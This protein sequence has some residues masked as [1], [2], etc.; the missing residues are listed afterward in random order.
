MATFSLVDS[1]SMK[2]VFPWGND[3]S[4]DVGS[5]HWIFAEKSSD[6]EQIQCLA[7][8]VCHSLLHTDIKTTQILPQ[9]YRLIPFSIR[10][11]DFYHSHSHPQTTPI[12]TQIHRLLLFSPSP[13]PFSPR[14]LPSWHRHTDYSHSHSQSHPDS[15]TTPIF[16]QTSPN[17]TLIHWLLLFSLK[18]SD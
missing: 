18:H 7:H 5:R 1:H 13:L 10:H 8:V 17:L 16:T 6:S 3:K 11:K 4:S 2:M 12:L 15:Q 9:T 14:L